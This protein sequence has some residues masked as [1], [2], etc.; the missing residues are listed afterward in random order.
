MSAKKTNVSLFTAIEKLLINLFRTILKKEEKY[1][2]KV[3]DNFHSNNILRKQG[4]EECKV[5]VYKT[6][7]LFLFLLVDHTA[8]HSKQVD[9]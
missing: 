6:F 5:Q 2:C 3:N 8:K 7:F 9:V 1:K 4:Q